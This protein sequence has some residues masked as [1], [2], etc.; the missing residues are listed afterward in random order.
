MNTSTK[1]IRSLIQAVLIVSL[2]VIWGLALHLVTKSRQE[3]LAEAELL[4][5]SQAHIFAEYSLSNVKRL[6]ELLFD[7][8]TQWRGDWKEFAA[9]VQKRKENIADISFQVAVI[10]RNGILAF[11]NLAKPTE[12]TDLSQREHFLVHAQHPGEDRLFISKPLQ[13]KV[14]RKW[15]IQFTRPILRDGQ[16]DGVLVVSV[17][18]DLFAS[19]AEKLR[20]APDSVLA[21]IRSSGEIMARYPTQESSY[22]QSVGDRPYLRPGAPVSG[23]VQATGVVDGVERLFGYYNLPELGLSFVVGESLAEAMKR[24]DGY[25][26]VVVAVV[27]LVTTAALALTALLL[28]SLGRLDRTRIELIEAK[29]EADRANRA[30]SDFLATMSHEIRTPLNGIIGLTYVLRDDAGLT[31]EQQKTL[32][33]VSASSQSLLTIVNDILDFSKIEAGKLEI[34]NCLFNIAALVDEL[35]LL[36]Q[37]RGREKQLAVHCQ[38]DADLPEWVVGDANRLRQILNNFLGNAVKFTEA[39]S[40]TLNVRHLAGEGDGIRVRFEVVDTGIG[41]P[42]EARQRLFQP[43][44]QLDA[45]QSRKYG[46]TGLGLAICKQLCELLGG[47]IGFDSDIGRGS[48][49]WVELPYRLAT[50]VE[51]AAPLSPETPQIRWIPK[52]L[53]VEDNRINQVVASRLLGKLGVTDVTLANDGQEAIDRAGEKAVDLVF[54]DCQ[55]PNVDGYQATSTLRAAGFAKPI[56]AMTANATEDD[57]RLCLSIG[58]NDFVTK[59]ITIEALAEVINKWAGRTERP[60]S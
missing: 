23:N 56:I 13:G 28:L 46:G 50:P 49:F 2:L 9:F 11:S 40:V 24:H 7:A 38:R 59:P 39:G 57:R 14:S 36:Y 60:D 32:S 31:A 8:R 22:G 48:V 33:L 30:K 54:M 15:S 42:D 52:V 55:M 20:L 51:E 19:F 34:E 4:T 45:S 53:L 10:D 27:A 21:L 1:G 12:R 3:A 41:I 6:N 25:R 26:T 18:P 17:S 5:A 47:S 43:F 16:F 58:M 37:A 35:I 44:S 29:D